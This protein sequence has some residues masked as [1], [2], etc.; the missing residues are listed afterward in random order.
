MGFSSP[1]IPKK[2]KNKKQNLR[3]K[4]RETER[5]ITSG[6]RLDTRTVHLSF[7]PLIPGGKPPPKAA[8]MAA[9]FPI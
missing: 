1:K 8:A 6:F 7:V 4:G 9:A 3:E 5:E 2:S